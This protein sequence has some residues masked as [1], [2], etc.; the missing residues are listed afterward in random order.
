MRNTEA[1]K[2]MAQCS[3]L[4]PVDVG[5]LVSA[6]IKVLQIHVSGE[7][8]SS[9]KIDRNVSPKHRYLVQFPGT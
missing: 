4:S 1:D 3:G 8:V 2:A 7:T 6:Y 5:Q 9:G